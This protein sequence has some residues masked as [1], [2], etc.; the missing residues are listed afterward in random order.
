MACPLF[1][2]KPLPEPMLTYCQMDPP[3]QTS[4]NLNTKLFINENE[5]ENVVLEMA[6]IFL[7]GTDLMLLSHQQAHCWLQSQYWY[8][9]VTGFSGYTHLEISNYSYDWDITRTTQRAP[10]FNI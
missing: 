2:A 6:A 4:V 10:T 8:V 1:G 5:F 7:E 9:F 3:Q